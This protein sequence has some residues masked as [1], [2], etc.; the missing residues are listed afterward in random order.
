MGTAAF[1]VLA[2]TVVV[3]AVVAWLAATLAGLRRGRRRLRETRA[4]LERQIDRRD[5]KPG[6]GGRRESFRAAVLARRHESEVRRW[7]RRA[8]R[9]PARLLL[10]LSRVEEPEVLPVETLPEPVRLPFDPP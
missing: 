9:L 3:S 2:S 8:R 7:R 4:Q 6:E 10:A 1:A 5:A